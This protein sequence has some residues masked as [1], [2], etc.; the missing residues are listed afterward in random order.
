MFELFKNN[1]DLISPSPVLIPWNANKTSTCYSSN[2]LVNQC[3][4]YINCQLYE[5][6]N[7]PLTSCQVIRYQRAVDMSNQ[8]IKITNFVL[9]CDL[10]F[11]IYTYFT[12]FR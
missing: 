7:C 2:D 11:D 12:V 9:N 5:K 1:H 3:C 6:I 8:N 10:K 4:N